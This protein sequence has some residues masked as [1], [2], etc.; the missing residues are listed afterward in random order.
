MNR[1]AYIFYDTDVEY[2]KTIYLQYH[3]NLSFLLK[4]EISD[5]EFIIYVNMTI[6]F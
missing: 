5:H 3:E 6:L 1:R 2:D 4:C